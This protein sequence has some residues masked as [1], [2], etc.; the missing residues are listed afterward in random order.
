MK[1]LFSKKTAPD[2]ELMTLKAELQTAQG[3][4][5]LAYRRFNRAI[6]P[7]LVES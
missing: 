6:D 3:E 4:L 1:T 2:P 7:E 5:A